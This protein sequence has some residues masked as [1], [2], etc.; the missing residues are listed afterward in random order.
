M[1]RSW[2][3]ASARQ[4]RGRAVGNTKRGKGTKI[5]AIADASGFP[6]AAHIE[7]AS[8]HEVKLVDK[9]IDSRFPD[10]TPDP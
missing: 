1:K 7:S 6:I 10:N 9:T 5:T 3:E 2:T 4:K 8:P